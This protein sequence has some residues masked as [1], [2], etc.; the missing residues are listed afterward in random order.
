MFSKK[1]AHDKL[2]AP[3]TVI[4][5]GVM[6]EAAKMTGQESIR[7][8]GDYKGEIDIDASLVLGDTGIVTGDVHARYIVVAGHI[9]GNIQCDSVLHFASTAQVYGDITTQALIMDEG[10]QV[11]GHYKVGEIAPTVEPYPAYKPEYQ[12]KGK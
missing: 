5:K 9:Q 11:S 12:D 3:N 2:D 10:S 7:I 4:G 6:L 8:D 1:A